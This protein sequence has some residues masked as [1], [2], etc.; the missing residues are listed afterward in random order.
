M[1]HSVTWGSLGEHRT[2]GRD[3]RSRI[4]KRGRSY[5]CDSTGVLPSP[6]TRICFALSIAMAKTACDE[7]VRLRVS[8]KESQRDS[9]T[10][11]CTHARAPRPPYLR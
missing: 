2:V 11:A 1:Q 5:R 7:I 6:Q 8:M 3:L 10:S 4:R 9:R